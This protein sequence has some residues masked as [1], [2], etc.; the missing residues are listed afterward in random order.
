M[1]AAFNLLTLCAFVV[2][3]VSVIDQ[4][5]PGCPSILLYLPLLGTVS[6]VATVALLILFAKTSRARQWTTGRRLRNVFDVLC[7]I[8]FVPY[9]IYW[10]LVGFHF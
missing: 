10:N 3:V 1:L 8:L 2:V 4:I 5:R 9:L 6:T 7:L